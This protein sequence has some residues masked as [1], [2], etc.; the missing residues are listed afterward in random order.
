MVLGNLRAQ[1]QNWITR[2]RYEKLN[3]VLEGLGDCIDPPK[4]KLKYEELPCLCGY[5][6]CDNSDKFENSLMAGI[7]CLRCKICGGVS[8][9]KRKDL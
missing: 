4:G 7:K 5:R 1:D 2:M 9:I 6:Y 3:Y 8:F